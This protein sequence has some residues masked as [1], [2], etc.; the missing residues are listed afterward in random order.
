MKTT[1]TAYRKHTLRR[2]YI[3]HPQHFVR[4]HETPRAAHRP[5][6]TGTSPP[7]AR[8][9]SS[10]AQYY[11][12]PGT[13]APAD[14]SRSFLQGSVATPYCPLLQ[15]SP[16]LRFHP[17]TLPSLPTFHPCGVSPSVSHAIPRTYHYSTPYVYDLNESFSK[18]VAMLAAFAVERCSKVV[19][20]PARCLVCVCVSR[21]G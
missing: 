5:A 19:G 10:A 4:A 21:T 6:P 2:T 18:R 16:R 8:R 15:L 17:I 11:Q 1:N 13:R 9:R 20:C 3:T 12:E 14:Q 7:C